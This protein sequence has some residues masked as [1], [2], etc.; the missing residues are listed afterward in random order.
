MDRNTRSQKQQTIAKWVGIGA[1]VLIAAGT[2]GVSLEILG[3]MA[4]GAALATL[5]I[6]E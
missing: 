5:V 2:A 4:L 6:P 3:A 1:V